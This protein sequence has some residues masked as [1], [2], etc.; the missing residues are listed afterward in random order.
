MKRRFLMITLLAVMTASCGLFDAS[1]SAKR[2]AVPQSLALSPDVTL[3]AGGAVKMVGMDFFPSSFKI[4]AGGKTIYLDPVV[5]D[6]SNSADYIFITHEHADHLSAADIKKLMK[7][8]TVIV[9][10]KTSADPLAG[11][12]VKV[13]KPGDI[14]KFD[15]F[16]CEVVPAYTTRAGFLGI[17]S[18]PKESQQAGYILTFGK[19]RIYTMGDTEFIPEMKSITNITVALTPIFF[20]MDIP[21]AADAVNT[22]KPKFAVPTHYVLGE[23]NAQ[24]FAEL[25]DKGIE[26]KTLTMEK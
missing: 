20:C 14:L 6:D 2:D 5:T 13:V 25:V 22:I 23:T 12:T 8:G 17:V 19:V 10:T 21:E 7:P 4:V 11:F 3:F 18:H 24:K 26:V 15:G 16:E 1:P 9:C